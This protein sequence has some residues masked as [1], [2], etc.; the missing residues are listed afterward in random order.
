LKKIETRQRGT[1]V[2]CALFVVYLVVYRLVCFLL[3]G[4]SLARRS[5]A[6]AGLILIAAVLLVLCYLS[7]RRSRDAFYRW[8]WLTLGLWALGNLVGDIFWAHYELI[9]QVEPPVLGAGGISYLSAYILPICI[10]FYTNWKSLGHL[11]AFENTLD[12]AI[13]TVGAAG[14]AWPLILAPMI[15]QRQGDMAFWL[16]LVYPL[17]DMLVIFVFISLIFGYYGDRNHRPPAWFVFPLG[18]FLALVAA[19][20][21]YL[22]ASANGEVASGTWIDTMFALSYAS[23]AVGAVLALRA[24]RSAAVEQAG[25]QARECRDIGRNVPLWRTALP[26]VT[27]PVLAVMISISASR[28]DWHWDATNQGLVYLGVAM[29]FLLLVRQYVALI[30]NRRLYTKVSDISKQLEGRVVDLAG[31]NQQLEDLNN[32]SHHLTALR[33]THAV[34]RAGLEMACALTGSPGGWLGIGKGADHKVITHGAV[35]DYPQANAATLA[36]AEARGLLCAV[37]LTIRGDNLGTMLLLEPPGGGADRDLSPLVAT[38]VASALDNAMRYEEALLLAERDPLTELYNHRGIHRRLTGEIQRAQRTDSELSLIMIDLDD[39]KTLNDTFGHMAGDSVLRQ[40]SDSIRAVLR[41]A[42]LAGRVGGDELMVVLP[43]TGAEGV[44]QLSER[45]QTSLSAHP[46]LST[47]GQFVPVYVS[48]GL[49]TMPE[50]GRSAEELITIADS[51]LYASKQRGGNTTTGPGRQ[52]QSADDLGMLRIADTLLDAVGA[53]DHYIRRHSDHVVRN[54]VALG[55]GL[56]LSEESLRTLR[57][58]A[59]LHDAGEAWVSPELVRASDALSGVERAQVRDHVLLGSLLAQDIPR[60]AE[61]A[62]AISAHHEHY[63][64]SGYPQQAKGDDIPL[65]G[66]ILAVADAYTAMTMDRRKRSGMGRVRARGEL[67][68][69][70]GTQLD[71]ELVQTFVSVLDGRGDDQTGEH[72]LTG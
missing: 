21:W 36:E 24:T 15:S 44:I 34:A 64:G 22:V 29:V 26:Y 19:D 2:F 60:L 61:V 66:R 51:N 14:L 52:Q 9:R 47:D 50:D 55:E 16:E 4:G 38:Q 28:G 32:N 12:A 17:L 25:P 58:A 41:H 6:D 27:L 40:V 70:A 30:T 67:L 42:D 7:F 56:G 23:G 5:V 31:V 57:L 65:L 68:K 1:L 8:I 33:Q 13:F 62:Q 49:A 72:P 3:P 53:R 10:I 45:L 11:K 35:E 69:V 71:P 63:D 20:T 48:L 18:A 43:N 54:A 39:F 59:T 37:P 46:Y